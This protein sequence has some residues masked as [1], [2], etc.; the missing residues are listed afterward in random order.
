MF[1]LVFNEI[2]NWIFHYIIAYNNKIVKIT[3]MFFSWKINN[4]NFCLNHLK[5]LLFSHF[6]MIQTNKFIKLNII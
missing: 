3:L 6:D 4:C 2:Y 5:L 1:A